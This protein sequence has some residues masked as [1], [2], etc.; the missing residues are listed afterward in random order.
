[1]RLVLPL[2]PNAANSRRHW[3]V[4]LKDK[5]AYWGVLDAMWV[6]RMIPPPTRNLLDGPARISVTYYI[7]NPMD[8]DNAMARLKPLIDWLVGAGYLPGDSRK[9]LKWAGIPEQVIDRK[10]PRVEIEISEAA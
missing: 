10:R 2:P 7:W 4:A 5:K 1:M 8:D 9:V 3:R 6:A